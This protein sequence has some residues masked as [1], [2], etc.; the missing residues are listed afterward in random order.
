MNSSDDSEFSGQK[1]NAK[2]KLNKDNSRL[3]KASKSSTNEK[4]NPLKSGLK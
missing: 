2:S 1:M 4:I 3:S